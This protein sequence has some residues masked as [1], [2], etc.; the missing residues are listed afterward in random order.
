M[1]AHYVAEMRKVQPKRRYYLCGYSFGGRVAVYMANLLKAA[2]EEVAL[3]GIID[4]TCLVGRQYVTFGQWMER[5]GVAPG[6]GRLSYVSPYAWFRIRKAY[7]SVYNRCRRCTLFPIREW[8]RRTGRLVPMSMRRPDRLNVLIRSEHETMPTY[9]GDAVY[10]RT[11]IDR[12][13]MAHPDQK[14]SWDRVITGGLDVVPVP[15]T[16]ASIIRA[17]DVG[18]VADEVSRRIT[19]DLARREGG[20]NDAA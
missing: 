15:G 9:D 11:E 3:L 20:R 5:L 17:R 19:E 7:D 18:A 8:Y 13:S 14:N 12:T 4:S 6:W 10:F 16:H 1:A 2:G